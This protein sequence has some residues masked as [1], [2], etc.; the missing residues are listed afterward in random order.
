M[1]SR[2]NRRRR[3]IVTGVCLALAG[4]G[5]TGWLMRGHE[6]LHA[7]PWANRHDT[8]DLFQ[9]TWSQFLT[10][11]PGSAAS[12]PPAPEL[13]GVTVLRYR[14]G[15]LIQMRRSAHTD[16]RWPTPVEAIQADPSGQ[17]SLPGGGSVKLVAVAVS[18]PSADDPA[19][20]EDAATEQLL[21]RRPDDL[22]E[23]STAELDTLGVP[24]STRE[25]VRATR[26]TPVVRLIIEKKGLAFER[27]SS[28]RAFDTR[29]RASVTEFLDRHDLGEESSLEGDGLAILDIYLDIWHDTPLTIAVDLP[30]GAPVETP[31]RLDDGFQSAPVPH[32]RFQLLAACKGPLAG[33]E[34]SSDQIYVESGSSDD[35]A[36][37]LAYRVFPSPWA[38]HMALRVRHG[39]QEVIRALMSATVGLADAPWPRSEID[40][41]S[42]LQFPQ[43]ARAIFQIPALPDMPNPRSVA[44]LFD[45][46]MPRLNLNL[47][48]ET[49][50]DSN[51]TYLLLD[52]VAGATE[53]G[54]DLFSGHPNI[55]R[56]VD[57]LRTRRFID[58]S[59]R[60]LLAEY[61][62]RA[63]DP[64]VF[65]SQTDHVMRFHRPEPWDHRLKQWWYLNTPD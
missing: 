3:L 43:R 57:E 9:L 17:V 28:F 44:N 8:E 14:Q 39:E 65:V 19:D 61:Q 11:K 58:V 31:V 10:E 64:Y 12:L 38:G 32:A 15:T 60:E 25:I 54:V 1:K 21:F 30:C 4:S 18:V 45:V 48:G 59:P 47:E 62:L 27:I 40:Q 52:T 5:L 55:S 16:E 29:T 34:Q 35:L 46:R 41:V 2:E 50:G 53:T 63:D 33:T 22:S 24:A 51:F 37:V 13:P 36:T 23:I 49:L 20:L 26:W 42:L 6:A 7:S 56:D